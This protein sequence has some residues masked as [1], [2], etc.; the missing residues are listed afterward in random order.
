MDDPEYRQFLH[1]VA[2]GVTVIAD[3]WLAAE[4]EDLRDWCARTAL[5]EDP[6]E[7]IHNTLGPELMAYQHK[8][9]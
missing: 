7:L 4:I 8:A 3:P 6:E 1:D 2:H 9:L 5:R